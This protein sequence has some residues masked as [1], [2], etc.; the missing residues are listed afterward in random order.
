MKK[1]NRVIKP[2][3]KIYIG[4]S[5]G[6]NAI[7]EQIKGFHDAIGIDG[8]ILTKLDCDAKGGTA[9]SLSYATGVP[10]LFIGIG[11]KYS[12]IKIFDAYELA[13]QMLA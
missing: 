1:M 9:I 8:A 11:Q 13:N 10:I 12:D 2:D 5:I 3:L 4:E 6:G 7:I